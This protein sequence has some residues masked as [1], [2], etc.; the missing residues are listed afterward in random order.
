[1]AGRIIMH[2]AYG[3]KVQ[4]EDDP[5]VD[6]A[7]RGLQALNAGV[8]AGSFLVETIPICRN[9]FLSSSSV[10]LISLST[11]KYIPDWFPGAN[12]KRL[13]KEWRIPVT[14]MLE[15]P[16]AYFKKRMAGID[17]SSYF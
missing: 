8:N 15:K 13:A 7:E 10:S 2:A 1:M 4:D 12:F 17:R 16:Y 6:I 9:I 5:Y 11:V 14:G 3:I